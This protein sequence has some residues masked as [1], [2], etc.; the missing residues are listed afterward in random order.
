MTGENFIALDFFP[1]VAAAS[2]D[3]TKPVPVFPTVPG[4]LSKLEDD[5]T[6]V[7]DVVKTTMASMNALLLRMNKEVA[8][9]ITLA[10]ADVRRTLAAADKLLNSDAPIQQELRDTLREVARAAVSLRHLGDM[11]ERQ[12]EALIRGKKGD[13]P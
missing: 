5:L 12:P 11:L 13:E 3:R 6:Q 1:K 4:K 2:V 10:L 7:L 8:P 9:E